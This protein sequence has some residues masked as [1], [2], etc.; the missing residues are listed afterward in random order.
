MEEEK[1]A[2][3]RQWHGEHVS[4]VTDM[5]IIE[6]LEVFFPVRS[7]SEAIYRELSKPEV[8]ERQSPLPLGGSVKCG[9]AA[10]VGSRCIALTH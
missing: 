1:T 6:L 9:G 2:V 3:V 8:V 4:L 10:F 7:V 5:H